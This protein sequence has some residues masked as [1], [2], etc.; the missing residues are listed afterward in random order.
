MTDAGKLAGR[1]A[2]VTGAARGIGAAT[3]EL[4]VAEGAAVVLGDRRD[5]L[6]SA[7]AERLS[8]AGSACYVSLDVT[9]EEQWDAAVASALA[10]FGRLDVLVN[11]A[12][13]MRIA[14]L[15]DCDRATFTKVIETN[16]VGAYL[17]MR[18]VLG[19]MRSG[20]GGSIVNFSSPQG[21]EGR[22]GM[23]AYTASKFAIRGLTRTAAIELGPEGIRVNTVVPGPTRTP[24]TARPGWSDADY[25]EAY[26]GYPLGRMAD[27][28][29]IAR[30]CLFLACDDSSFCTGADFVVDGGITAG[31]PRERR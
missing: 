20:G 27:P 8:A 13:I 12:G 31:K 6:G 7:L 2:L 24:M 15:A 21:I 25:D 22:E 19:A 4:F 26:G 18:A 10:R 9:S 5:D 1:V 29:E 23:S 14:P 28:A 3:A 17:G 11:N 30:M 16:L